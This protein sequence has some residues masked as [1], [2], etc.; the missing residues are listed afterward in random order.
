MTARCTRAAL[1]AWSSVLFV[2]FVCAA[3]ESQ[4]R[5]VNE[6]FAVPQ[7]ALQKAWVEA[8]GVSA[9]TWK[10][11]Q[12]EGL[13][14]ELDAAE[15][16]KLLDIAPAPQRI[17]QGRLPYF[18]PNPDGKSWDII[19]PYHKKYLSEG[20][21]F[22]HDFGSG[23]S[24]LFSYGTTEG[25]NIITPHLSVAISTCMLSTSVTTTGCTASDSP[26]AETDSSLSSSTRKRTRQRS[27]L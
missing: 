22:V 10:P 9:E 26:T 12:R 4:F 8:P 27:T 11:V 13:A 7:P 15:N 18:C 20:Q 23:E 17:S 5:E 6:P 25:Q 19:H 24:K 14:Q 2:Q 1:I 21:V 16:L 3:D